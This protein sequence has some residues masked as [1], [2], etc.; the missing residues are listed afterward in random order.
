M[1]IKGIFGTTLLMFACEK[2]NLEVVQ[3]LLTNGADMEAKD[4]VGTTVLMKA[5]EG[6]HLE[7]VQALLAKDAD[8]EAKETSLGA[9]R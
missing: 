7:V 8:L 2:G 5:C 6:G 3:A 9:P 4:I 1:E